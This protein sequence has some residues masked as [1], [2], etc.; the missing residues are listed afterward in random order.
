[1]RHKLTPSAVPCTALQVEHAHHARVGVDV[2]HLE[3]AVHKTQCEVLKAAISRAVDKM[4][5]EVLKEAIDRAR[6]LHKRNV[7]R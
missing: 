1:M 4:Q 3:Q 5:S 7:T 6:R 2:P